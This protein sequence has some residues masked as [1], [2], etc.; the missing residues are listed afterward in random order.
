MRRLPK[1]KSG[2]APRPESPARAAIARLVVR[3]ARRVGLAVTAAR[4]NPGPAN[5]HA[6]RIDV[7]RM[8]AILRALEGELHPRLLAGIQFD[9]KNL[10]RETGPVREADVRRTLLIPVIRDSQALPVAL[11]R[12]SGTLLEQ[13]RL[14][15]RLA[16][17][18][19]M[20][21]PIW[22]ARIERIGA[23]ARDPDL[24][25]WLTRPVA[26][27]VAGIVRRELTDLRRRMARRRFGPGRLHRLRR[28]IRD[29]RYAVEGLLPIAHR[30][31]APLAAT[32]QQVQT[33]LGDAHDL[34]EARRFL[35]E[36]LLPP[37]C[38]ALLAPGMEAV[39]ARQ[40]KRCRR[41]V[42]RM[43]TKPPREWQRWLSRAGVAQPVARSAGRG[44][45]Q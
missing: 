2:S 32:L 43:A 5:L 34:I 45:R 18:A 14:D 10:T 9:L 22:T 39:L 15:A 1:L 21:D 17:R 12:D 16:M 37:E 20:R 6:L 19:R 26:E 27:L 4:A 23:A 25:A 30:Q 11:K 42:R 41:K 7:R 29:V 31:A 38:R 36:D 3:N 40:L 24:I 44:A 13:M 8:R 35:Q 28:R 33:L